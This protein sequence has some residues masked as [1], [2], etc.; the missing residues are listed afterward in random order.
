[1][2]RNGVDRTQARFGEKPIPTLAEVLLILE[3][4]TDLTPRQR[5][6]LC[7]AVRGVG[8]ALGRKPSGLRRA[9]D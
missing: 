9:V 1:M 5:T 6:D 2:S 3:Q 7:S 4:R 8:R